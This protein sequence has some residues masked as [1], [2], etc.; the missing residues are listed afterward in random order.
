SALEAI[1]VAIRFLLL[2]PPGGAF[3]QSLWIWMDVGGFAS[4]IGLYLDPL[5]LVMTLVITFVSVLIH[6]YSSE[7]MIDDEGYS[8][9]FAYMNL[10]V[11]SM[12]TLV[13][14]DNLLLL[15]LGWEGVG[16]CS[17][18]L[19]G[20]WY[21]DPANG[22]AAQKAFIVTRIGDS[23][24]AIG[25]FLLFWHLGTLDLQEMM[26]RASRQ[27][28]VGSG[29]AT[30]A[31]AL[32]LAGALGKSAQ[33]PLQTWLPDAMA[34]PTPVSALI[35][36]ATMVTA[37]VYLIAR[38]HPLYT[39][40]PHVQ[41]AVAV[42]GALTLLVAGC[43]ALVQRDI[44]R[45]LAYSTI[46]QIGYMFLALGVGA[47]SAAMFHFVTH[48]F[49]KAL[50]FLAAGAVIQS[51]HHEHDIFRMGGLRKEL[52]LTFW[53]FLIGSA[54][55]AGFPLVTAGFYSKDWILWESWSSSIGSHWLWA[56]GW[57][58]ALLTSLYIFRVV[59]VVFFGAPVS[60]ASVKPGLRIT[61]PLVILAILSAGAG[62]LEVPHSLGGVSLFSSFI[63]SALP[64]MGTPHA[65][66]GAEMRLLIL[67]MT[68]SLL[69]IYLAYLLWHRS[70]HLGE[71][72]AQSAAGA[73]LH[74]FWFAGWGCDW[75]YDR[76]VVRPFVWAAL[77]NKDDVIDTI[78]QG[79]AVVSQRSHRV[80]R[81]SQTGR[82]RSYAAVIVAGSVLIVAIVLLT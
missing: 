43:S 25:L 58:G 72:I 20:F 40:T 39:L 11:G 12:L 28:P 38:V 42:I 31:A 80:L 30:A 73:A 24:M 9:F 57:L 14:A 61:I 22:R 26:V 5:S 54:S 76:L 46:S 70:P 50:L 3:A 53:T 71:R 2:P 82:V 62:F 81:L 6:L 48:A 74:R 41:F 69:G 60:R 65:G 49:F 34:G 78:Y 10:F 19:I 56:A 17:Y 7:F 1:L 35:H 44:K 32:L 13:L 36:A 79:T 16:L 45:V 23:A 33:L 63:E 29:L 15:Y 51:L 67:A 68:A 64:R 66:A 77:A 37:G 75:L 18:L 4:R 52:P 47:W 27:W 21:T 59:F 55:L 8:R